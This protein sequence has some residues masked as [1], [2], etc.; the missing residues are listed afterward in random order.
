[1]VTLTRSDALHEWQRREKPDRPHG[2]LK[3]LDGF[4]PMPSGRALAASRAQKRNRSIQHQKGN[5]G[6]AHRRRLKGA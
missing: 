3:R 2:Q 1:M 4:A 6:G 5:F